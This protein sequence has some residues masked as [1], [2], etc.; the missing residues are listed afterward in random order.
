VAEGSGARAEGVPMSFLSLETIAIAAALTIPPLVAMYFLKLKRTVRA[1]PS[2]LLWKR[3]VEDL[4]VNAPF[5]RLRSSLLLAL[6]LLVLVLAAIALGKPMFETADKNEGTLIILVDQSASMNVMEADG[7]TRLDIAKEQAKHCIDN[8]AEDA[9]AMVIAFCDRANVVSSFDTDRQ[10]LKRKIDSIE[11][12]QSRS[13]LIEAVSLAEAYTQNIMIGTETAGTDIAPESAAPPANVFAFTDGRIG[14]AEDVMLERFEAGRFRMTSIGARSDNVGI[15][16]MDAR[17]N[18]EQPEVLEVAATVRN[19]G[20]EPLTLDAVLYVDGRNVDVQSLALEASPARPSDEDDASSNTP[21]LGQTRV[22]AF[23]PVEF[24]GG[25]LVE[26][27]LHVDDALSADNRAWT[28]IDPPRHMRVLLV[29]SENPF[30]RDVLSTMPLDLVEMTGAEYEEAGD[31]MLTDGQRSVFDVVIMDRHTTGR[32]PQGNYLFFGA[33]PQLEGVAAGGPIDDQVIFNWDEAHPILRHVAV[34]TLYVYEWLELQ[35]PPEAVSLIDGETSPVLS[36]FT[37]EASQFLVCAF[38]LIVE[39]E[40]G[41]PLMNTYWV[42]TADFVVFMQN[43]VQY[44]AANLATA[45]RKSIGPGEPATLPA[46]PDTTTLRV[47][48]PDGE[49]DRVLT[50]RARTLHYARTRHVGP[51]RVEPGI[52]GYDLFA[53]NLFDPVE[54]RVE[55][56][57]RLTIGADAVAAGAGRIEVSKPAWPFVLLAV[58]VLLLLEWVVYNRRVFV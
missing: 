38:G 18:Y 55:P 41:E 16:A 54:S 10:A 46:P 26:V 27:A 17:R 6:Q 11:P 9:R 22:V 7:R 5:Q 23:D 25:G 43:A 42:T 56:A 36:Y 48:R 28:V 35:L 2:T 39:G 15:L 44:L 40:T 29:T 37:R 47:V 20:P 19:F 21:V 14:D 34:E 1:V 32:L 49:A 4:Q 30:L 58:L 52:P 31:E 24:G 51:Y 57:D 45:G 53:V 13:S 3:A 50:T 33:V 8:M 12:T